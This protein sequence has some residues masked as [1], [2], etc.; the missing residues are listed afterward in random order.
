MPYKNGCLMLL[1]PTEATVEKKT[2]TCTDQCCPKYQMNTCA[3][4]CCPMYH[5]RP[6]IIQANWIHVLGHIIVNTDDKERDRKFS[7][8]MESLG[9]CYNQSE[10]WLWNWHGCCLMVSGWRFEDY[11]YNIDSEIDNLW[12]PVEDW[13]TITL[14]LKLTWLLSCGVQLKIGRL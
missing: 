4:Q 1:L 2:N 6:Q 10:H 12:C 8:G 14:T 11:N 3:G 5:W 13:K 9:H 7:N